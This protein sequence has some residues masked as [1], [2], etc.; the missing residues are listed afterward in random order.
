MGRHMGLDKEHVLL[1]VQTAGDI[2]GQLGQGVAAQIRRHLPHRDGVHIRQHIVAVIF[3][4]QSRPV[5]DGA[6]IGAQS[7]IAGGLNTAENPLLLYFICHGKTPLC[8]LSCGPLSVQAI[9]RQ[10]NLFSVAHQKE[11]CNVLFRPLPCFPV[12]FSFFLGISFQKK[13][14]FRRSGPGR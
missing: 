8:L 3:I 11:K 1:R 10:F 14:F 7:Q 12:V 9:K 6:Q 4:G 2:D 13:R 5:A